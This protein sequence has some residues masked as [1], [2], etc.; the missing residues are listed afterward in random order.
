MIL[1]SGWHKPKELIENP[2]AGER[3]GLPPDASLVKVRLLRYW[4]MGLL[5]RRK[6]GKGY[7]YS[8]S[9]RGEGYLLHVF[10]TKGLLDSRESMTEPERQLLRVR[11]ELYEILNER[12]IKRRRRRRT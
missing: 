7:E 2:H 5:D 9:E 12:F 3:P 4:R 11:R 1:H 8:I 10:E 6:S